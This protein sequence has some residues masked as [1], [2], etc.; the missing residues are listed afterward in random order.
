M[1][2]AALR[3]YL[4]SIGWTERTGNGP[5]PRWSAGLGGYTVA[6]VANGYRVS[7]VGDWTHERVCKTPDEVLVELA[8]L[9]AYE[10]DWRI[11]P[12]AGASGR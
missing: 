12:L 3:T 2:P 6:E 10:A 8:A 4:L 11:G 9:N 5:Q 1:T 7:H